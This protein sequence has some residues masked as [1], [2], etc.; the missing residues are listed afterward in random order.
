MKAKKSN[1][2]CCGNCANYRGERRCI[3]MLSTRHWNVCIFYLSD[4]KDYS[5]RL[6]P[7]TLSEQE[8][9]NKK[10]SKPKYNKNIM[11]L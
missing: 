5:E 6:L 7:L 8:I 3:K 1:L 11:E 4:N 2:H 10:T 9:K